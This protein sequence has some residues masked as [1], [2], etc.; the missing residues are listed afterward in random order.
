MTALR[1]AQG[2]DVRDEE[3]AA[4]PPARRLWP[5]ARRGMAP[6]AANVRP[7]LQSRARRAVLDRPQG[8]RRWAARSPV[9]VVAGY[10]VLYCPLS[11]RKHAVA[12]RLRNLGCEPHKV[13]FEPLGLQTWRVNCEL[14]PP[15]QSAWSRLRA[16]G[17]SWSSARAPGS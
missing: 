3:C 16:P 10:H 12:E 8:G 9:R 5:A 2:A 4:A 14:T 6:Q 11:T 13:A 7:H 17:G 15:E 1:G